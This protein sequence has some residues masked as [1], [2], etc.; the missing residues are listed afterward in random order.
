[1]KTASVWKSIA[2]YLL[3][4]TACCLLLSGC[5]KKQGQEPAAA[6]QTAAA[7]SGS[8]EAETEDPKEAM[9][10]QI[11]LGIQFLSQGNYKEALLAFTAAI[12]IDPKN[13][14]AYDGRARTY[15]GM[16]EGAAD[17]E[18]YRSYLD[19]AEADYALAEQYL[20]GAGP[21][22]PGD[23]PG[24]IDPQIGFFSEFKTNDPRLNLA[25]KYL[26]QARE[27]AMEKVFDRAMDALERAAALHPFREGGLA[28]PNNFIGLTPYTEAII[29]HGEDQD[30]AVRYCR[31]LCAFLTG[32][33]P[34]KA[35]PLLDNLRYCVVGYDYTGLNK[36][37]LTTDYIEAMDRPIAECLLADE[38]LAEDAYGARCLH[39]SL[40]ALGEMEEAARVYREYLRAH[41]EK[42]DEKGQY[43][44]R[45][46]GYTEAVSEDCEVQ[47]DACGRRLSVTDLDNGF[48]SV[49][50]TYEFEEGSLRLTARRSH[51]THREGDSWTNEIVYEYEDGRVTAAHVRDT[52][53]RY[54]D[55]GEDITY[56]YDGNQVTITRTPLPEGDPSSYVSTVTVRGD[57]H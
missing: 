26:W 47:Y 43:Q 5:G 40:A 29:N 51:G 52:N 36:L 50:D 6:Q 18:E 57:L 15:L 8:T 49:Y 21:E 7:E 17:F 44:F 9:A 34:A 37:F 20:S 23:I 22:Y 41:M 31:I 16:A 55:S 2:I 48:G 38:R 32:I 4:L 54:G 10:E 13:G 3:G 25:L 14:E 42:E 39:R 28:E 27:A 12:E 46:D 33:D 11:R 19:L 1:M 56:V 35:Q 24:N 45:E 30:R 53:S